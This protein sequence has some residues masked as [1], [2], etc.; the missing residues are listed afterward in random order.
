MAEFEP[1]IA[2]E[3]SGFFES[4]Y[5]FGNDGSVRNNEINTSGI[6]E[7]TE[8]IITE[9]STVTI[10]DLCGIFA[11]ERIIVKRNATLNGFR[12]GQSGGYGGFNQGNNGS[13]GSDGLFGGGGGRGG[14][15]GGSVDIGTP[16]GWENAFFAQFMKGYYTNT[17]DFIGG[18]GGGGGRPG[19]TYN[20]YG[21]GRCYPIATGDGGD[22][23]NGGASLALVSPQIEI[24]STATIDL[25]GGDGKPGQDAADSVSD[26]QGG[27][28]GGGGGG[29]CCAI[30]GKDISI[31]EE[32]IFVGGGVGAP[33]GDG[34]NG[35]GDGSSGGDG[36]DGELHI[37]EM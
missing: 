18:A 34:A 5:L 25:R 29:G 22:G 1:L 13:S 33:G 6:T 20:C 11:T 28:G 19:I 21:Y 27:G 17:N 31:D 23:G 2:S 15:P 14:H 16:D 3:S 37:G 26:S 24:H 4:P 7:A 32:S 36:S 35:G 8:V 30:F 9:G 12:N 10:S